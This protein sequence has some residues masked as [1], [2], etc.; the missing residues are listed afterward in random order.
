MRTLTLTSQVVKDIRGPLGP[1]DRCH[2]V[3]ESVARI[4]TDES[5]PEQTIRLVTPNLQHVLTGR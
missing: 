4:C 5:V 1:H 2:Y 3:V